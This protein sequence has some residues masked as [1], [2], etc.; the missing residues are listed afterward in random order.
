[1]KQFWHTRVI[2]TE[3]ASGISDAA[4]VTKVV[5]PCKALAIRSCREFEGEFLS[6]QEKLM[7]SR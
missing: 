3:D 6:L 4:R 5:R 7:E 1:M 2:Y